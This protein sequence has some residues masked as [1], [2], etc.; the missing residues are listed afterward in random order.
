[1]INDDRDILKETVHDTTG[2]RARPWVEYNGCPKKLFGLLYKPDLNL[3]K[4]EKF[5]H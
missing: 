2:T 5:L 4:K 3:I 1:M